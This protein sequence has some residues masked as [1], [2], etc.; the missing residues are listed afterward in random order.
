MEILSKFTKS[1]VNITLCIIVYIKINHLWSW[2]SI[3][4]FI[5]VHLPTLTTVLSLADKFAEILTAKN[6]VLFRCLVSAHR[7]TKEV[8]DRPM[9]VKDN[10]LLCLVQFTIGKNIAMENF[11][12]S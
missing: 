6:N 1:L 5:Y 2:D 12:Y 4:V 8:Y 11:L 10:V 3:V 9:K 7:V